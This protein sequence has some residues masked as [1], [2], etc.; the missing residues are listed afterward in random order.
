M[1]YETVT[2]TDVGRQREVNEDS[3]TVHRGSQ[4][5]LVAVADGMGGHAAGD[6]ASEAALEAFSEYVEENESHQPATDRLDSGARAANDRLREM[7]LEDR[8]LDGMGTTLVAALLTD[9]GATLV[10]VGDSR[11]YHLTS[12]EIEQV[13]VDQSLVQQ[14]VEQGRITPEEAETHPQRNVVSQA[15]GTEDSVDPDTYEHPVQGTLLLCSDGLPEEVPESS[16]HDV[17]TGAS[18]LETAAAELVD[19]ANENGGSD[20][21]TVALARRQ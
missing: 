10:N 9:E 21:V 15:L 7:I 17:V 18:D 8:S 6:V 1:S 12:E 4:W 3:V 5:T 11:A 20:N 19:C 16:I 13:T 2:R 14:L